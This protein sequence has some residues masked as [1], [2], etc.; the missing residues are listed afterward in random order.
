MTCFRFSIP[1]SMKTHLPEFRIE[2]LLLD[3]AH[4]AYPVFECCRR[5]NISPFIDLN[6]GHFTYK[7]N[8][9][10]DDDGVS[11]C[12]LG[13]RMHK[14]GYEAAKHRA[15]YRCQKANRKRGCFCEHPCSP[16]K[17]GRIV[18]IFTD[19]NLRSFGIPPKNFKT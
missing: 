17:Y 2:K 7:D 19:D 9:T 8:L 16:V 18:H 1:F 11:V 3:S 12:K 5:E 10:I 13:L 4:D 15:K 14:N 6:L